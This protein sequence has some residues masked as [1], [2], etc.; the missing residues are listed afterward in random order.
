MLGTG[1]FFSRLGQPNLLGRVIELKELGRNSGGKTER[2]SGHFHGN[3]P[4]YLHMPS[5]YFQVNSRVLQLTP[6]IHEERI[7]LLICP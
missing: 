4:K 7:P 5:I 6:H 1:T 2:F 3:F